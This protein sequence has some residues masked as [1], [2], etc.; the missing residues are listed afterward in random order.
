MQKHEITYRIHDILT[1]YGFKKLVNIVRT[2][3]EEQGK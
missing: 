1:D 3:I 2:K